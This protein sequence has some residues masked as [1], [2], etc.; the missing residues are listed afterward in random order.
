[1]R[2]RFL[3][4]AILA[5]SL[6][7]A[8]PA[9]ASAEQIVKQYERQ[10]AV[11]RTIEEGG[12]IYELASTKATSAEPA[13][14]AQTKSYSTT[15][16]A[17]VAAADYN[18]NPADY[19]PASIS[20]SDDGYAGQVSLSGTSVE[21]RYT[22]ESQTLTRRETYRDLTKAE[23]DAIPATRDYTVAIGDYP[24]ATGPVPFERTALD[25]QP[26]KVSPGLYY[27]QAYYRGVE[28]TATIDGYEI[29][30]SYTGILSKAT[31]NARELIEAVYSSVD[32]AESAGQVETPKVAPGTASQPQAGL[33][34]ASSAQVGSETET[35]ESQNPASF[36]GAALAGLAVAV[37]GGL[38]AYLL[39][40]RRM[41]DSG[42]G[43]TPKFTPEGSGR[44]AAEHEA[45]IGHSGAPSS[46]PKESPADTARR[47][48]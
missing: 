47:G 2:Q 8:L 14:D 6:A 1:M 24:G 18:G 34:A 25:V 26:S 16:R 20:A 32:A 5:A 22:V 45:Q 28:Q 19:L 36:A 31:E 37:A 9:T 43:E 7:M 42:V 35:M 3:L 48:L 13:S 33:G 40:N 10:D 41:G 38:G 39:F 30:G 29:E 46:R 21:T 27:A 44:E 17:S 23:V 15:Q 11:P 4:T 12:V